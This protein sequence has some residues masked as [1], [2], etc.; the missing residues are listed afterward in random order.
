MTGVYGRDLDLNLL[1]VFGVVAETG[2]VTEAAARLYLTQ[3]AVSAALRRLSTSIGAEL[4]V[5]QGRN[6]VLTRR[7]QLLRTALT[8]HLTPLVEAALAAPVFD[9]ETSERALRVG[10]SD[11][12]EM[13]LL[14][15]LLRVL[16]QSAPNMQIVALPIQFRTAAQALTN[17]LD[18]AVSV[19]DELPAA[20]LRRELFRGQFVC[21]FD[22]RQLDAAKLTKSEYFKRWHVVVSYNGDLRGIVEDETGKSRKVRCSVSSF[23]NLGALLEGTQLVATIPLL[24]AD[25]LRKTRPH[26]ACATVPFALAGAPMELLWPSA[27]DDDPACRFVRQLIVA[28]ST[29]FSPRTN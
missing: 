20:I 12:A 23:A 16:E 8:A 19:A 13:W 17:A 18:M 22:G 25:Q 10:F 21:M 1:R 24:V 27:T 3:P 11:A 14:P 6:M 29:K 15:R 2:S 9:P 7:G 26:L 4:F 5:R 28:L